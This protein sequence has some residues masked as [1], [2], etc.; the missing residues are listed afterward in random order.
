MFDADLRLYCWNRRFR[1]L[2]DLPAEFGQVGTPLTDILRFN[3]D[4]GLY[5]P[6][7]PE[8]I[9]ADRLDQF[10]RRLATI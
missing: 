1:D 7:R 8:T 9:V 4:R 2:L 10:V 5:G 6:G 3:A